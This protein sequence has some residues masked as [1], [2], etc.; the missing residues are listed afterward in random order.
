VRH[1]RH[2]TAPDAIAA[3]VAGLAADGI[4]IVRD[5]LPTPA[6]AALRI[7][8]LRR[9]AAGELTPAGVGRAA[10]RVERVEVRGDRT[11]WLDDAEPA[12]AERP[13]RA[14]LEALRIA[15]N[16]ELMLGLWSCEAHYALY[17]IGARY[18]RHLD[19]FRDDDARVVS[20]VLYLNEGWQAGEGGALRIHLADGS[21]RDVLPEAGT[22]IAFLSDRV[23]HEVLPAA[24]PR[25]SVTGWFR[26]REP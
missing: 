11:A 17:P 6:I 10:A 22:F 18:A 3:V 8:A 16:R 1:A 5:F 14:A 19:R 21:C 12:A 7:E 24:R 4:A 2:A 13:F 20:C 25:V 23:E 9:D 26:R 15:A